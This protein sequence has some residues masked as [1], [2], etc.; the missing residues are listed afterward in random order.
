MITSKLM[1]SNI[2]SSYKYNF[3][4]ITVPSFKQR[5]LHWKF[6]CI[7]N[8]N[9]NKS[10]FRKYQGFL[11]ITLNFIFL[12]ST[13]NLITCRTSIYGL[14]IHFMKVSPPPNHGKIVRPM[15]LVHG[16]PGSFLEFLDMI[17][18]LVTPRDDS[19]FVFEVIV[20]SIPGYGFSD[21]PQKSG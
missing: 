16:W 6:C 15:L 13:A 2:S 21:A 11:M 20:P 10:I 4:K 8:I 18:H 9:F 1:H 7:C 19:D 5:L 14:N 3:K 17:P 12:I